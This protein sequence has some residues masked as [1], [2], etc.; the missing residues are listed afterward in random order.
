MVGFLRSVRHTKYK[1]TAGMVKQDHWI[2]ML[3]QHNAFNARR[4]WLNMPQKTA[5]TLMRP[6]FSLVS[7]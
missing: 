5:G 3:S 4:F 7:Y 2:L 1:N 6:V